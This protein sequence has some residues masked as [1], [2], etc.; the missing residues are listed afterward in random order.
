M[1]DQTPQNP[2]SPESAERLLDLLVE[3]ASTGLDDRGQAELD[4]LLAGQ[5]DFAQD[6]FADSASAAAQVFAA[7][8]AQP[9]PAHL[10]ER[11]IG[12]ARAIIGQQ[13]AETQS[14]PATLK[15][16]QS[17]PQ[18]QANAPF[19]AQAAP[20]SG[21]GWLAMGWLAAAACLTV[22][23][24][25]WMPSS[26]NVEV[27]PAEPWI[28]VTSNQPRL[29]SDR[30]L[31]IRTHAEVIVWEWSQWGDEYAGVTGDVV[32]DPE[33]NK[34][35]MRFDNLPANDP[36][37]SRYQL[38]IV[39]QARGTPLQVPPVD[40]GMFDVEAS[41]DGQWIVPFTAHLPVG[42]VFGFGVTVE[43]PDGVVVSDQTAK[44]VIATAPPE[45][46]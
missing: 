27:V 45:Q 7:T 35:Y 13:H 39:D 29:E 41:E 44:A 32:W 4:Q 1:S 6:A 37:V 5:S 2:G 40:G 28:N 36:K 30:D 22:A 18:A 14:E 12:S 15:F 38:W 33:T 46:G 21:G 3:Q 26:R 20:R 11:C 9:M 43:G 10:R 8:D 42:E 31:F 24:L 34:G 25:G 19:R 23:V 16:E 17:Q